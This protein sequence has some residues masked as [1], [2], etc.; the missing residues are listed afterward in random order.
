MIEFSFSM[1]GTVKPTGKLILLGPKRQIK[2]EILITNRYTTRQDVLEN[3][4]PLH[5]KDAKAFA[6]KENALLPK[7][8]ERI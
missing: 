8:S 2:K 6:K 5:P 4:F 7:V 3:D 1:A